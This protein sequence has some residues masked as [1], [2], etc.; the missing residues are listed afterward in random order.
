M[1]LID[2]IAAYFQ[3]RILAALS[4][5]AALLAGRLPELPP[6][7]ERV[8]ACAQKI[9]FFQSA[10]QALHPAAEVA[11]AVVP[12]AERSRHYLA[13][14]GE[15]LEHASAAPYLFDVAMLETATARVA[16]TLA[17]AEMLSLGRPSGERLTE[18]HYRS[19]AEKY[20]LPHIPDLP[21]G[22]E[23]YMPEL[24]PEAARARWVMARPEVDVV[25]RRLGYSHALA[26]DTDRLWADLAGSLQVYIPDAEAY[27]RALDSA[28]AALQKTPPEVLQMPSFAARLAVLHEVASLPRTDRAEEHRLRLGQ[29]PLDD[30]LP[31]VEILP[32][33][34]DGTAVWRM[35]VELMCLRREPADKDAFL[36]TLRTL[37]QVL[38]DSPLPA[39]DKLRAD[40][41]TEIGAVRRAL[42]REG[43]YLPA[44]LASLRDRIRLAVHYAPSEA[45]SQRRQ[46]LHSVVDAVVSLSASA[47]RTPQARRPLDADRAASYREQALAAARIALANDWMLVGPLARALTA[48]VLDTEIV[49]AVN[50]S[51]PGPAI[52]LLTVVR[53]EAE[54]DSLDVVEAQRRLRTAESHGLFVQSS[55]YSL[56]SASVQ[57]RS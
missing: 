42:H 44:A 57:R 14:A 27:Y 22:W 11:P 16:E 23:E 9:H 32:V 39:N 25:Y 41:R 51:F 56:L 10:L 12:Y 33:L 29:T 50:R 48:L 4:S 17:L 43:S 46:V 40:V 20:G 7:P 5:R 26:A 37:E 24:S 28:L 38:D 54:R 34:R 19:V 47:G 2:S 36:R 30:L 31:F 53:D 35:P 49:L 18:A 13:V 1:S 3:P 45:M 52:D 55:V 8:S 21:S 6:A 15:M